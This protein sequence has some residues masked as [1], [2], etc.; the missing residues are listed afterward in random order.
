MTKRLDLD[1]TYPGLR[2][3][4]GVE[5]D[6]VIARDVGLSPARVGQIRKGLGI[7]ALHQR[8]ESKSA[9]SFINAL[10]R[11]LRTRWE[12]THPEETMADLS[13]ALGVAKV[14][15][16]G[17]WA[18]GT[19]GRRP[20]WDLLVRFSGLVD[21]RLILDVQ[22]VIIEGPKAKDLTT[23]RRKRHESF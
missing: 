20:N 11:H 1:A 19:G 9:P 2:E 8:T 12:Q 22:G 6:P 10:F 5:S 7:P 14:S 4:L 21:C 23:V 16:M 15:R 18:S 3:R 13:K 17:E